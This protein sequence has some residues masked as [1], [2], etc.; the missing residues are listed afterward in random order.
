MPRTMNSKKSYQ[1]H[2]A[3]YLSNEMALAAKIWFYLKNQI[4]PKTKHELNTL[5]V[6]FNSMKVNEKNKDI[7]FDTGKAWQKLQERIKTESYT[8]QSRTAFIPNLNYFAVAA[9]LLVMVALSLSVWFYYNPK[10]ITLANMTQ[11][12]TIIR[13]LPDGTQIFLGENTILEYPVRFAGKTRTVKLS[14]EAYFDVAKNGSKPFI[15]KTSHA[16][17]KVVGTSFN[18]K[19]SNNEVHLKVTEG[20]VK[21]TLATNQKSA[22]VQAG[23]A[24][25]ASKND[26]VTYTQPAGETIKSAMKLLMFQDETLDNIVRVINSTYGSNIKVLGDDLK[27]MR[28]SVTFDNDISSI[29]NILSVSFNLKVTRSPDGTIIISR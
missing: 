24:A 26:I 9:T 14:G 27:D 4:N 20:K 13:T 25:I 16:D 22:L 5:K 29:V 17:V 3:K 28:I 1:T 8:G 6:F 19:T 11:S 10:T 23:E 21:I 12:S 2:I 7:E 15:I 18:L